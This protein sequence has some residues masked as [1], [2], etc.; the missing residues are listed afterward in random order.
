MIAVFGGECR[1]CAKNV[2][3]EHAGQYDDH[4]LSKPQK[5]LQSKINKQIDRQTDT[6]MTQT[7][8]N[9]HVVKI[10]IRQNVEF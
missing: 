10:L 6:Q 5:A 7:W 3:N 2:A 1:E 4:K 8:I 9:Y